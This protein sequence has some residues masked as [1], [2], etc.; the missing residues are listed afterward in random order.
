[1]KRVFAPWLAALIVTHAGCS[2]GN[3]DGASAR[4]G[5]GDG[6]VAASISQPSVESPRLAAKITKEKAVATA[7]ADYT[8]TIGPL[9]DID[10]SASEDADGWRVRFYPHVR[11][12]TIAGGGGVYLIGKESGKILDLKLYQ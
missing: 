2:K 6:R 8:K 3:L 7:K 4:A 10:F 5:T 1:M 11:N 9:K 12:G